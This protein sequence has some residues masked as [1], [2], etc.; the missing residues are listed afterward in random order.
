MSTQ[1]VREASPDADLLQAEFD[2]RIAADQ[3]IEP[4]DWMPE[5]YRRTLVRQVSQH[6]HSEIIG[7]QP[8]G[9]WIA[10]APS[11]RR[12]AILLAKVQD[13]AGHGLYLY[14]AAE[15]LGVDRA[16][17]TERLIEGRQK[18]SSIFN[19]P[20]LTF[21]DVGVI[22]W[23]VDGAAICN[24]VPLCRSSFG[25]Y[26]RAMVRICKE[27]SF[28]QRQGYE[29]LMRMMEG[30]PQQRAMV[31]DAVDRWWWPSLMMFGPPDADS[32]NTQQSMAWG[33]KRDT[34][35][36][37]R[38]KFVDMTVP[39][40]EKLGVT[41]PDPELVWNAERG[42]HDFGEPDWVEFKQVISGAGPKNAERVQRRRAAHEKGAW[43]RE[44]AT[45][46][47]RK[48]TSAEEAAV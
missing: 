41:L 2:A 14:A 3:R 42:H 29:L 46:Y 5:G 47:A 9:D 16:D 25:P 21:A 24:Q 39:Q 12:K 48:H 33:I 34:N 30:T 40:A 15:T 38:Q 17:L 31:Q 22:G 27:E 10:S 7:M 43:V 6:A 28:H 26:A 13:E 20:S 44:A 19:Y 37:L 23:L 11:L 8:E 45:A 35:D 18:Y 1:T 36:D 32:P 4:R